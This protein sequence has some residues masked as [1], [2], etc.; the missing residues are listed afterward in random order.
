MKW[1]KRIAIGVA[2]LLVL[3]LAFV[4]WLLWTEGGA[5]FAVARAQATLAGKLTIGAVHG[6]I[7]GPLRLEDVRYRD[8]ASGVDARVQRASVEAALLPLWSRTLHVRAR[9][10]L[11]SRQPPRPSA[12]QSP[13]FPSR[14]RLI[15]KNNQKR[16]YTLC[17]DN[18]FTWISR[19][20][21]YARN[22]PRK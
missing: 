19:L 6:A 2:A 10:R 11:R 4:A 8:P 20:L 3:A 9:N 5:R 21:A 14:P 1:L 13:S 16:A 15:S 17:L 12:R 18:P 22:C 7:V